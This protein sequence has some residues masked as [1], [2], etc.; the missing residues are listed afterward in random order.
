MQNSAI[1]PQVVDS[2]LKA[3]RSGQTWTPA[4]LSAIDDNASAPPDSTLRNV[5][6]QRAIL[7]Y[8]ALE[9]GATTL[10]TANPSVPVQGL[11]ITW[12]GLSVTGATIVDGLDLS[13][14]H[15]DHPMT[16]AHCRFGGVIDFSGARLGPV[17][18]AGS[19][20][21]LLEADAA[22]FSGDLELDSIWCLAV[23]LRGATIDGLLLLDRAMIVL[24][25]FSQFREMILPLLTGPEAEILARAPNRRNARPLDWY[26]WALMTTQGPVPPSG[27]KQPSFAGI[28]ESLLQ[29]LRRFKS[30]ETIPLELAVASLQRR[31]FGEGSVER[32]HDHE[33]AEWITSVSEWAGAAERALVAGEKLVSIIGSQKPPRQ[34]DTIAVVADNLKC[35]ANV[36]LRRDFTSFGQLNLFGASIGAGLSIDSARLFGLGESAIDGSRMRAGRLHFFNCSIAGTVELAGVSV[37]GAL[38]FN[39]STIRHFA[40]P[41]V[42]VSLNGAVAADIFL[43]HRTR[44]LGKVDLI[45][46]QSEGDLD[47]SGAYFF[48]PRGSSIVAE[49][50]SVRSQTFVRLGFGSV[51]STTFSQGRFGGDFV[52]VGGAFSVKDGDALNLEGAEIHGVLD[53][54]A[55][56][57][58]Q[59]RLNLTD[60]KADA[61]CDDCSG[62]GT[63]EP[64]G[65]L[66]W[67][68]KPR[69]E[70][71][72]L[73]NGF[74]YARFTNRQ[75]RL[76][77]TDAKCRIAWLKSQPD[78]HWQREMQPQPWEQCARVLALMGHADE[79]R[80]VLYERER[81]RTK[82]QSTGFWQKFGR[83]ILDLASG[84]GYYNFRALWWSFGWVLAGA[85]VFLLAHR[86]DLLERAPETLPIA[87]TKPL[88]PT[89]AE[90]GE[91]I[92]QPDFH[93]FWYSL[94]TFVPVVDLRQAIY[95]IPKPID[96]D[97]GNR[98][99]MLMLR[100]VLPGEL[101]LTAASVNQGAS[102][103]SSVTATF[104][105]WTGLLW[106]W[107]WFQII[108]GWVLT[109]I[110]VLGFTGALER[111]NS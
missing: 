66:S 74:T 81:L 14:L 82:Y 46:A 62:W 1:R 71:T 54:S 20:F 30:A 77:P 65:G 86:S 107:T 11:A 50:I 53:M 64:L 23:N 26:E 102:I 83:A 85:V 37:D 34:R 92:V 78:K 24:Q 28:R 15:F 39:R 3:W 99:A 36:F 5:E 70:V 79:A 69:G 19:S 32:P 51:G 90:S 52:C 91:T 94:D 68:A 12:Q 25:L 73:L 27:S 72:A 61:F 87:R 7:D 96:A 58:L 43:R 29:V 110:A 67:S 35:T 100:Q 4:L 84:Y 88:A 44:F 41:A 17:N 103:L 106:L 80:K 76:T 47:L 18:L 38:A 6:V 56:T 22:H 40:T 16:F 33:I 21:F 8:M 10:E 31:M 93:A 104:T 2:L 75:G 89:E 48:N 101:Q 60:T 63:R 105:T 97:D 57:R 108:G 13:G 111:R 95:W 9:R 59:G 109:T 49:R 55:I 42:A 98:E 45:G